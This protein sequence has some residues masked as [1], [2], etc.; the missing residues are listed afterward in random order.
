MFPQ[1]QIMKYF[2]DCHK[3]FIDESSEQKE[4]LE[5]EK[6]L[7]QQEARTQEYSYCFGDESNEKLFNESDY[8]VKEEKFNNNITSATVTSSA[9]TSIGDQ[10]FGS[11]PSEIFESSGDEY[12]PDFADETDSCSDIS[13]DDSKKSSKQENVDEQDI[14]GQNISE[15]N[16]PYFQYISIDQNLETQVLCIFFMG[17][18]FFYA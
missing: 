10:Q 2:S 6:H 4:P 18:F 13:Q 17:G 8:E 9:F 5:R 7:E 15:Q 11:S 16:K 3:L 1:D 14:I 12:V